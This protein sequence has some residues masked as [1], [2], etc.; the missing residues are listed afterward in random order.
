MHDFTLFI[1]RFAGMN[2]IQEN[3]ARWNA[4]PGNAP[5]EFQMS[6]FS[7]LSP[8]AQGIIMIIF[9]AFFWTCI[10]VV[11]KALS[12]DYHATQLVWVRYAGQAA[13]AVSV[14]WIRHPGAMRTNNLPLQV[15]RALMLLFATSTYF[16]GL[17][18][19]E[20]AVAAAVVQVNPLIIVIAAYFLLNESLGWKKLLGVAIG[21][22]GAVAIIRPGASVFNPYAFFPLAA[23]AGYAGYT[24]LTRHL[25]KSESVWTNFLYTSII[26]VLFS[27]VLAPFFWTTPNLPDLGLMLLAAVFGACGQYLV[28]RALFVA[29]ASV[30]SPFTYIS[31]VFAAIFG[32]V[33]FGE[34]PDIW[35]YAG[36]AMIVMSG[37]YIWRIEAKRRSQN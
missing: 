10:D 18:N 23:A 5:S 7:R 27:A 6:S 22:L 21:L 29:E 26:G 14:V 15:V 24:I 9:A 13:I 19:V 36:S 37:L 1:R 20:L 25:S 35:T 11:V 33:L 12:G 16:I 32:I 8:N 4:A 28:V 34:F 31:L 2:P 17:G 3:A 30:V